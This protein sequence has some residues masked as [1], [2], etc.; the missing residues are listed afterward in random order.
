MTAGF[1]IGKGAILA[2]AYANYDY[3]C[4]LDSHE[5]QEGFGKTQFDWVI[6]ASEKIDTNFDIQKLQELPKNEFYFHHFSYDLKNELYDNLHS[7]NPKRINTPLSVLMKPDW[8]LASKNG[9]LILIKEPDFDLKQI[10][11]LTNAGL[12][13]NTHLESLWTKEQYESAF[14]N[15]MNELQQGNI[16]EVNL[17]QE[18][19]YHNFEENPTEVFL[20][21]NDKAK[22]P[23]SSFFKIKEHSLLSFSPERYLYKNNKYIQSQPIK[24]TRP[25]GRNITEDTQFIEDLKSSLK[26]VSENTMIVDLVRND[27][28][29]FAEKSSVKVEE[30]CEIY[31]FP[32][33]HQMIS[34]ISAELRKES[35][36]WKAFFKAFPM[37]SMTGV[38]K[39]EAMKIIERE[40]DFQRG[41]YAGSIGFS[42]QEA[43]DFSVLI[44]TLI[45]DSVSELA[46]LPVGGAITI[47]AEAEEEYE[48]CLVKKYGIEKS[49]LR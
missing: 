48:E 23:F 9:E 43:A 35:D 27:L 28:S 46:T 17:C 25:R 15:C 29:H 31:T 42:Y 19:V 36:F 44:R 49:I 24:G 37:G 14:L 4:F 3:V 1:T 11:Q 26:E 40:E 21:I 10:D 30:L 39:I 20:E 38:P 41:A 34:T 16:Y 6:G 18:F 12:K 22:A 45:Y 7:K 32:H 47:R 13:K 33:V 5:Y 8:V 2:F